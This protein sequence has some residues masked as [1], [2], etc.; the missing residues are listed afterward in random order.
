MRTVIT[1]AI[2]VERFPNIERVA[3]VRN[4]RVRCTS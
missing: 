3:S 4:K 1:A 2:D